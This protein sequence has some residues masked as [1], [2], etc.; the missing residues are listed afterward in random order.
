MLSEEVWCVCVGGGGVLVRGQR[1]VVPVHDGRGGGGGSCTGGRDKLFQSMMVRGGGGGGGS[2]TGGRDK[3]FQSMMVLGGG[4]CS[5][6]S[7]STGDSL[8][9]TFFCPLQVVAGSCCRS[10]HATVTVPV[11]FCSM[12]VL[13]AFL[14]SAGWAI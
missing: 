5:F 3:L 11:V 9:C 7:L 13:A 10:S 14:Q 4:V 12:A 2:C 8:K 6:C 1:Q